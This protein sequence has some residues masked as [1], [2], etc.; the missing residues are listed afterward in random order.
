MPGMNDKGLV[1]YDRKIRKDAFYWYKANWSNDPFVHINSSRLTPRRS[2]PVTVRAYSNL[3]AVELMVNG[4]SIGSKSGDDHIFEWKDV[5]LAE[6]SNNVKARAHASNQEVTD[7]CVWEA[8]KDAPE[9]LGANS[10][11]IHDISR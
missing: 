1:T 6:G 3:G 5:S 7:S 9:K 4:K 11:I 8:S 2:G 10:A